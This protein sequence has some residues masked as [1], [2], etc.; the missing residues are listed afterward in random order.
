MQRLLL[1]KQIGQRVV[2]DA[3]NSVKG[4]DDEKKDGR[5]DKEVVEENDKEEDEKREGDFFERLSNI[6]RDMDVE[7]ECKVD[8]THK[9]DELLIELDMVR[10]CVVD[11]GVVINLVL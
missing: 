11:I 7:R 5:V 9:D 6:Q 2:E 1:K 8:Q 4:E 10:G 3:V